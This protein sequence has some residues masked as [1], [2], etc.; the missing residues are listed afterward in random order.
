VG[1]VL[2]PYSVIFHKYGAG[3]LWHH[4]FGFGRYFVAYEYNQLLSALFFTQNKHI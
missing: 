2:N 4:Q 1:F 3:Y